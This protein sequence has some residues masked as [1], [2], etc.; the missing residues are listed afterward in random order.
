[1]KTKDE[2]EVEEKIKAEANKY[3]LEEV[4]EDIEIEWDGPRYEVLSKQLEFA[5]HMNAE[6][7]VIRIFLR[8]AYEAGANA[9]YNAGRFK[10]WEETR[11]EHDNLVNTLTGMLQK[12]KT[13]KDKMLDDLVKERQITYNL[14]NELKTLWEAFQKTHKIVGEFWG[15]DPQPGG[16]NPYIK[17]TKAYKMVE[18]FDKCIRECISI[19]ETTLKKLGKIE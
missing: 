13:L 4:S 18:A 11:K 16:D 8:R 17:G 2:S 10:G 9:W 3:V 12:E 5:Q 6:N 1:M 14:K 7:S 15:C 19:H